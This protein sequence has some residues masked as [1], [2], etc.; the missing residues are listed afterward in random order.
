[1]IEEVRID[2]PKMSSSE[3]MALKNCRLAHHFRYDLGYGPIMTNSKLSVGTGVHECLEAA[4]RG[5]SWRDAL[6]AWAEDRWDELELAYLGS[7]YGVPAEERMDFIKH[8]ELI[9][10]MVEGYLEWAEAE[11]I[12]E[13]WEVVEIEERHY[14]DVGAATIMPMKFDLLL[15][16]EDSGRLK[17]VDFKTRKNFGGDPYTAYQLAEQTLNYAVGVFTLYGQVPEVE[18]REL[19]KVSQKGNSKPPFYRQVNLTVTKDEMLG[20]IEEYKIMAEVRVDE[21]RAIYAN[22]SSCCG[23]WKNDWAKPCLLVHQGFAPEEALEMSSSKFGKQ[24]PYERYG[25]ED[26]Q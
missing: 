21:N 20:R 6:E 16:H 18:Y 25:E 24:D 10:I 7:E 19:R 26:D 11:G 17:L 4:Y 13:G 9:E 14:I 23:S 22:P 1:M 3:E 5:D 8:K 2:Q 15:R 12:D